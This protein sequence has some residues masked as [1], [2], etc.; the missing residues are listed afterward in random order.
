MQT[1]RKK[2]KTKQNK[3]QNDQKENVI[4]WNIK[5]M[6]LLSDEIKI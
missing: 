3:T 5:G 1:K 2:D 4:L 6:M